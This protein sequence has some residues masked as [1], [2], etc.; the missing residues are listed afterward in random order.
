MLNGAVPLSCCSEFLRILHV[1]PIPLKLAIKCSQSVTQSMCGRRKVGGGERD[2]QRDNHATGRTQQILHYDGLLLEGQ[3]KN[4][5]VSCLLGHW[6]TETVRVEIHSQT[7]AIESDLLL[8]FLIKPRILR[9]CCSLKLPK[10]CASLSES[11]ICCIR[12]HRLT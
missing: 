6:K 8:Y 10:S 2:R 12:V 7:Q 3:T 9:H 1:D 5:L 4:S 11:L